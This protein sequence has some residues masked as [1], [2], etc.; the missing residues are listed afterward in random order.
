MCKR[1]GTEMKTLQRTEAKQIDVIAKEWFDKKNGNSYFSAE[2]T[3]NFGKDDERTY[4][5]P[6][7]Y[8]YGD[9]YIHEAK[10]VLTEHNEISAQYGEQLWSYC[11]KNGIDLHTTK[12][13]LKM[14]GNQ[15]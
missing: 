2:V 3:V 14:K 9:Q 7:Q 6:F 1:G 13:A 11:S 8:G 5:L 10:A 15:Y 12:L 4:K